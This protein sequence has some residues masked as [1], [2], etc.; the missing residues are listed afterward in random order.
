MATARERRYWA[1]KEK[2]IR[3]KTVEIHHDSI[4]TLRYVLEQFNSKSFTLEATA[5]RNASATVE[6][7]PMSGQL[8]DPSQSG[9]TINRTLSLGRVGSEVRQKLKLIDNSSRYLSMQMII[10]YYIA[11]EESAPSNV[12]E[13]YYISNV[14]I[15]ENSV[16][17]TATDELVYN[18][19][20]SRVY[21]EDELTGMQGFL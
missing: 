9:A 10:R 11:G 20:V 16:T 14:S 17:I 1:S 8:S 6:F 3:F 5:P 12:P 19:R 7:E 21:R 18:S 13:I 15:D 4:G 2:R